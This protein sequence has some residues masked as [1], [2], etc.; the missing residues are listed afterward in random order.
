MVLV[1]EFD[2][3]TPESGVIPLLDSDRHGVIWMTDDAYAV[4]RWSWS[5]ESG[6]L[7]AILD[8]IYVRTRGAGTGSALIEHVLA[9]CQA[10]GVRRIFLE[11]EAPNDAARRLYE[12]HGFVAEDSIWMARMNAV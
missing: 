11:T 1:H 5:L 2:P 12:R 9:D 8:E 7:E 3:A 6:G 4:V 10:R